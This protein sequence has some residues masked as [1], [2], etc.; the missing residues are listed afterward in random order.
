MEMKLSKEYR[1]ILYIG[2]I[3]VISII[4][5]IAVNF[6]FFEKWEKNLIEGRKSICEEY[7]YYITAELEDNDTIQQQLSELLDGSTISIAS[8]LK[9][10]DSLAELIKRHMIE[11]KGLEGGFYIKKLNDFIGYAFPTSDPPIPV[12]G[13]PPRSY[14]IIKNQAIESIEKNISIVDIHAFDPAIF[15]LATHPFKYEEQVVGS[16]WVRIHIERELPL[17]RLKKVINFLTIIFLVGFVSMAMF[18]IFLRNGIKNIRIELKD[19]TK[20]PGYRLKRRG[21]LFGFIP[22]SIN[23]ML[24]LI[25]KEYKQRQELEREL[26]QKEKL[27]SLGNMIAAVAHEV[28]TPLSIIKMRVQMWQK[29]AADKPKLQEKIDPDSFNLVIDEINRLS[30]LVKRLVVFSRPIYKNLKPISIDQAI[31]EIISLINYENSGKEIKIKKKLIEDLPLVNAD[32]NSLKQVLIN[33]ITNSVESIDARGEILIET[34]FKEKESVITIEISDS[35]K[36]IPDDIL[37]NIFD[38]FFT[39]KETGTGLGLS[40]SHE[41][42]AAHGGSISFQKNKEKG[43]KCIITLPISN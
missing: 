34:D 19:T 13:P 18:S 2:L 6:Y 1:K 16:V 4:A 20:D 30:G 39:S 12:Y 36:G 11:I 3:A 14:N 31:E 23:I 37:K 38:P 28:K 32:T 40:I 42:I 8:S 21:G 7:A 24:D 35:G 29:E 41:I 10:E 22:A 43:T 26:Q 9:I 5:I 25:E 15:P 33:I 17:T 27:A